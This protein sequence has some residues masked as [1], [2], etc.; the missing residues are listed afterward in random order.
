PWMKTIVALEGDTVCLEGDDVTING[1]VQAHRPLLRDYALVPVEGCVPLAPD[2]YFV[3]NEHP[4]SFDGRYVGV[5]PRTI[6][7]TTCTALYR[8]KEHGYCSEN[9]LV[10]VSWRSSLGAGQGRR[11]WPIRRPITPPWDTPS[12]MLVCTASTSPQTGGAGPG[13]GAGTSSTAS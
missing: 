2:T 8:W 13:S 7:R 11:C 10:S 12:G 3:L 1:V 4:R 9:A 5:F 6:I